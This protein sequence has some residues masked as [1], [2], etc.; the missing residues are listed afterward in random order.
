MAKIFEF[1]WFTV[2]HQGL[3]NIQQIK[4][5]LICSLFCPWNTAQA[6]ED[7]HLECSQPFHIIQVQWKGWLY[8]RCGSSD[9]FMILYRYKYTKS[10]HNFYA[11]G[12]DDLY[13]LHTNMEIY[14]WQIYPSA[15]V[16]ATS[17]FTKISLNEKYGVCSTNNAFRR[18]LAISTED[19]SPLMMPT[20]V[21]LSTELY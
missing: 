11:T 1:P 6:S 13:L 9:D 19:S 17:E 14:Q 10:Q 4:N 21:V 2:F 7:P 12:P 5:I 3:G 18:I 16:S 20:D 8:L 15:K